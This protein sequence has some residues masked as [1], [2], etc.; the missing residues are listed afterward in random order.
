MFSAL[1]TSSAAN[2]ASLTGTDEHQELDTM[3]RIQFPS[4]A[5]CFVNNPGLLKNPVCQQISRE[6]LS[7]DN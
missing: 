3:R 2:A 4:L 6:T 1:R 7:V 5:N